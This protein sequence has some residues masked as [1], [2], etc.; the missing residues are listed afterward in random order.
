[1]GTFQTEVVLSDKR[2]SRGRAIADRQRREEVLVEYDRSGMT[3]KAFAKHEGI[4]YHTLVSWLAWRRRM[5]VASGAKFAEVRL[6][7]VSRP[8]GLEVML[9]NGLVVR[10]EEGKRKKGS[11]WAGPD[12]SDS[13]NGIICS[14]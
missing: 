9:P 12:S 10:G 1:M 6:G 3:Q 2:D 5:G 11:N 14:V 7:P 8:A 13:R 4:K